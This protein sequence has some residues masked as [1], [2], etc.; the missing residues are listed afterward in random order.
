MGKMITFAEETIHPFNMKTNH[1]IQ[2]G[3]CMLL[4]AVVAFLLQPIVL[5]SLFTEGMQDVFL[6]PSGYIGGLVYL[7][8]FPIAAFLL[9]SKN[10]T[11]SWKRLTLIY[12][13]V[14]NT[15]IILFIFIYPFT[16]Q[17]VTIELDGEIVRSRPEGLA[18]MLTLLS[19]LAA[20]VLS[21]FPI[22]LCCYLFKR[23][24]DGAA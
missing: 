2:F 22:G 5:K 24:V 19:T 13:L 21:V 11:K 16:T 10:K 8:V 17:W 6:E 7:L 4:T 1:A 18:W 9:W 3:G 15:A 12:A 20:A 23:K 14:V